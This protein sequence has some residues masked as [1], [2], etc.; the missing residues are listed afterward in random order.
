MLYQG[1]EIATALYDI[2]WYNLAGR[3]ARDIVLVLAISKYPLK[4]MAGKI[5]VLSMSTFGMVGDAELK[6]KFS[7]NNF[8]WFIAFRC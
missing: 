5:L 2:E 7:T 8:H 1:S 4:L 3:K 6:M